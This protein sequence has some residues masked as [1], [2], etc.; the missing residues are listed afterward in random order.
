MVYSVFQK[1][2]TVQ[3]LSILTAAGVVPCGARETSPVYHHSAD[4]A[5]WSFGFTEFIYS[6]IENS[7]LPSRWGGGIAGVAYREMG[8]VNGFKTYL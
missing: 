8:K 6:R 4:Y 1:D 2:L 3:N 5:F 7:F